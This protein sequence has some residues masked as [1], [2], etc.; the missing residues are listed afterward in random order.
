M[1]SSIAY[2]GSRCRLIVLFISISCA[3]T[4]TGP[5]NSINSPISWR[6]R[7]IIDFNRAPRRMIIKFL[8]TLD[9]MLQLPTMPKPAFSQQILTTP[10]FRE[11]NFFPLRKMLMKISHNKH[12]SHYRCG[13]MCAKKYESKQLVR[14]LYPVVSRWQDGSRQQQDVRGEIKVECMWEKFF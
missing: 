6:K 9:R 4:Q 11:E 12:D 5:K 14:S 1:E 8:R 13:L 3:K 10:E 7:F 2:H